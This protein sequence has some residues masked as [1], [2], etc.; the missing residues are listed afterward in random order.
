VA[1]TYLVDTSV[2][3]RIR[4]DAVADVLDPMFD[5]GLLA[6]CGVVDLEFLRSARN[7]AKHAAA[8]EIRRDLVWLPMP[9]D[10]WDRAIAMQGLLAER[11]QHRAISIP[12]LLIAATAERNDVPVLHYDHDYE[13]IA[14]VT[15]QPTQWIVPRGTIP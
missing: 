4:Q 6:T 7:G 5:R 14:A 3:A 9:D 2:W 11:G 15:Q 13:L 12:G 8:R 10:V 1:V